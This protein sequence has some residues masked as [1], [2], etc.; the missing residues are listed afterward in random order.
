LGGQITCFTGPFDSLERTFTGGDYS[1]STATFVDSTPELTR[2][3]PPAGLVLPA[4]LP[5]AR[6]TRLLTIPSR[7]GFTWTSRALVAPT[8]LDTGQKMLAA[9]TCDGTTSSW[10][11]AQNAAAAEGGLLFFD[12]DGVLVFHGQARRLTQTPRW[13][14]SDVAGQTHY[15]SGLMFRTSTDDLILD[16]AVTTSDGV[17][18]IFGPGGLTQTTATSVTADLTETSQ[19]GGNISGA[20]RARFL[21]SQ[22]AVPRRNSPTLIVNAAPSAGLWTAAGG[23]ATEFQAAVTGNISDLATVTR[24]P[25]QG[26][27]ISQP[28][29]I[30]GYSMS[31]VA[32]QSWVTTFNVSR[33]DPIPPGGYWQLGLSQLGLNTTLTW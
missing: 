33:A 25:Y 21:Y 27:V 22:R 3:I 17:T 19:L 16:A 15:E 11:L 2:H 1:E 18:S 30:E 13:V 8:R 23:Q 26:T 24:H 9:L 10:T 31:A 12:K 5:G 14:F 29:W 4:E 7:S 28:H 20:S 6:I 32:G